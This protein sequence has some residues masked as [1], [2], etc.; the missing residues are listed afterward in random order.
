[1]VDDGR[2]T[3]CGESVG[4]GMQTMRERAAGLGGRLIVEQGDDGLGW[5]VRA[6]LPLF[7]A[8]ETGMGAAE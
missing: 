3:K 1:V 8:P 7:E 6:R 5:H 4:L 2:V